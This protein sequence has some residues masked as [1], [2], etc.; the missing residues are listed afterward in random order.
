MFWADDAETVGYIGLSFVFLDLG[1]MR[2]L[3]QVRERSVTVW[4]SPSAVNA[5]SQ[6]WKN[7]Y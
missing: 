5:Q 2:N 1:K 3:V 4:P 7:R 6:H